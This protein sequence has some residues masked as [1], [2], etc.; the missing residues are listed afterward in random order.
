MEAETGMTLPE[1]KEHLEPPRVGKGKI[2]P[3]K[4]PSFRRNVA[5]AP[6]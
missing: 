5:L 2:L 4:N 1:E 6:S 3:W